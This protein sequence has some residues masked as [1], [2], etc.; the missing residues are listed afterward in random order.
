MVTS[1]SPLVLK[2]VNIKY[3]WVYSEEDAVDL[4]SGTTKS[5]AKG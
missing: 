2:K 5:E 4:T 1:P 3:D